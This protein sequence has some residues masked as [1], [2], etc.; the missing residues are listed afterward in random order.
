MMTFRYLIP[1]SVFNELT[2]LCVDRAPTVVWGKLFADRKESFAVVSSF[3]IDE[4]RSDNEGHERPKSWMRMKK[5]KIKTNRKLKE[6]EGYDIIW[7]FHTHPS[8]NTELHEIDLKI[9]NYLSMGVMVII[10]DKE[11]VGW[12]Y[13]KRSTKK[14]IIEKM[15]Y[16]VIDDI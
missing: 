2:K 1:K 12:Y 13:D 15:I 10:T 7:N 3:E 14:P 8:G 5:T 9:L 6:E 4:Q 16:E 11:I